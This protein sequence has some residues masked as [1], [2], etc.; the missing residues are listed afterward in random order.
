MQ[1]F[2]RKHL[3][4]PTILWFLFTFP[5]HHICFYGSSVQLSFLTL[6]ILYIFQWSPSL[7][8]AFNSTL[9]QISFN[10]HCNGSFISF[11]VKQETICW[12]QTY[13]IF[14]ITVTILDSVHTLLMDLSCQSSKQK[15]CFS[16]P[17]LFHRKES[18][19]T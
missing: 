17:I 4:F 15:F 18:F 5:S 13:I 16:S 14:I 6:F 3:H 11:A 8:T 2:K 9:T 10:P 7:G 12:A 1:P 19:L